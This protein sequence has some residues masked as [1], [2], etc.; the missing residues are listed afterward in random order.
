VVFIVWSVMEKIDHT[1][2]R[3]SLMLMLPFGV[4]LIAEHFHA[5][6]VI[7]VVVAALDVRL[8]DVECN[9]A[10]RV[11]QNSTWQVLEMLIIC[12][13]FVLLGLH[14]CFIIDFEVANL[15]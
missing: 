7:A 2:A 3:S 12:I 8:R 15:G 11:T 1:I 14:L 9:S 5:S 10:E 6:G 13:A 4:Y